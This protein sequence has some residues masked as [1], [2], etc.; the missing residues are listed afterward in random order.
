ME[1]RRGGGRERGEE[2]RGEERGNRE[3]TSEVDDVLFFSSFC[4]NFEYQV[5]PTYEGR[6]TIPVLFDKKTERIVNNESSE[7]CTS[8]LPPPP[9]VF[10]P[11][12]HPSIP[13]SLHPSICSF[14]FADYQNIQLCIQR[15]APFQLTQPRS[16]QS[17]KEHR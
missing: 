10:S 12:L 5:E 2:E 15:A 13:P 1:E 8:P 16:R 14:L 11:S 6:I 7:V 4:F 17:Q 3:R 9:S